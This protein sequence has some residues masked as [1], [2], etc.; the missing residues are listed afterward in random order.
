MTVRTGAGS[1]CIWPLTRRET[2]AIFVAMTVHVTQAAEGLPRRPFT[3]ADV[4]RMVEIGVIGRDERFEL[5]GGEIVPMSPKG[6]RH[7]RLKEFLNVW[8][9]QHYVPEYRV[10]QETTFRLS[11]DTYL[12]PDFIVYGRD[13][14]LAELRGDTCLLAI[15]IADSSLAYDLGHKPAIYAGFGVREMWVINARSLEAHIHRDPTPTGYRTVFQR[16]REDRLTALAIPG[17]SL[18]LGDAV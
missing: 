10:I 17:H 2:D 16:S 8:L 13:T 18:V 3:I 6:I 1:R 14:D 9:V 11:D 12:E 7:E 4:E 5:I 15:E